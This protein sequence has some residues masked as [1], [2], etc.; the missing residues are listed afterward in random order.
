MKLRLLNTGLHWQVEW[1]QPIGTV[2]WTR[3]AGLRLILYGR[4]YFFGIIRSTK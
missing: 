4:E 3:I 2:T 1:P